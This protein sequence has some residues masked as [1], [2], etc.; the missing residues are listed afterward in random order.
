LYVALVR[1]NTGSA[2][3]SGAECVAKLRVGGFPLMHAA[4]GG[5]FWD[6]KI[7]GWQELKVYS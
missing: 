6:R 2:G 1:I 7:R 3:I 5:S 4:E